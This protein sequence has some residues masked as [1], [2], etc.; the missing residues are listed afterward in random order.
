M[1][2]CFLVPL[3]SS[4]QFH[5]L[6]RTS[7]HTITHPKLFRTTQHVC[8]HILVARP[9]LVYLTYPSPGEMAWPKQSPASLCSSQQPSGFARKTQLFWLLDWGQDGRDSSL[10]PSTKSCK[11]LI[12]WQAWSQKWG[13]RWWTRQNWLLGNFHAR[14]QNAINVIFPALRDS[15]SGNT[16]HDTPQ[17]P[18][19]LSKLGHSNPKDINWCHK[20]KYY[21]YP[22]QI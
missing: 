11:S 2:P 13:S 6:P 8:W 1:V 10:I 15:S 18:G 16:L 9:F 4:V 12:L 17:S 19:S 21:P 7:P 5:L 20:L 14:E 22:S 3:T